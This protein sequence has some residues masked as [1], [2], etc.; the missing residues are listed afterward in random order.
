LGIA[1]GAFG[2]AWF[3][4]KMTAS[5]SDPKTARE[6]DRNGGYEKQGCVESCYVG[7]V[8]HIT[9][10]PLLVLTAGML[11]GSMHMHGRWLGRSGRGLGRTRAMGRNL[12]IT[13]GALLV[14]GI[15]GL[16]T[17]LLTAGSARTEVGYIAVR[18]VGWWSATAL[19]LSG[20][21]LA[22][23]GH[24]ILRGQRESRRG[25]QV[26]IAPMLG[27]SMTGISIAGRF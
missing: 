2:V 10:S 15:A 17:G 7:P 16:T 5:V 18:E 20:A 1:A 14:G 8:F 6:I 19:G 13:G 21:A 12:A 27:G 25:P 22:G 4:M 11:G 3:G 9:G 23:L 24:G 26:A